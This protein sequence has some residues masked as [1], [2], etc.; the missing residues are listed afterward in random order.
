M[1]GGTGTG[2]AP[3]IAEIARSM[4]ILTVAVVTKPFAFEGARRMKNAEQG[5]KNL[6]DFVDTLLVIPNQK[7]VECFKDQKI[8]FKRAFEIADD[9]LRQG[10]YGRRLRQGRDAHS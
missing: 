10:A 3:V 7:L 4:G 9:V 6:K 1:G 5:I 2:A 8:T